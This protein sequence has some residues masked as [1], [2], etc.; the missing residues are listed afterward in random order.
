MTRGR[1]TPAGTATGTGTPESV[2]RAWLARRDWPELAPDPGWRTALVCS[3]H[4]DDDVL[5]VGGLMRLLAGA[6]LALRLLAATDGE[7][8]HPGSAVLEPPEL[9]R[10]RVAETAAAL[11]A[12][13]VDPVDPVRLRLPD[14]A[15]TA[16]E[17]QLTAAVT[18]AARG[19]DVVLAPW[20][21]DAHPDHE[22]VGRAACAAA[23]AHGIPLLAFPVWTWTWS[24]P[25]DP[26]VPWH[27][28]RLVRLPPAVQAARRDAVA[29]FA[30]QVRPLGPAPEDAVVLPPEVLEHFDRD[31]EVVFA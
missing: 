4:P 11:A 28:A 1:P 20:S 24:G 10:R 17:D 19:V 16:V 3:A 29:C 25:D 14:S 12:L 18:A 7:A 8:S 13:G 5:A 9:A 27:R 22:A 2:W 21:G 31:V 15:L 23:A 30:T 26:R 6:G